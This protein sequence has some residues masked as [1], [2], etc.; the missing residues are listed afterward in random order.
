MDDESANYSNLPQIAFWGARHLEHARPI[1]DYYLQATA[2]TLPQLAII[3]PWF[4]APAGLSNDD[5][6]HA[7][8]RLGQAF[9]SDVGL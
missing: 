3:D 4:I 6:P 5:H 7:D 2:G 8:I 1:A 9:I